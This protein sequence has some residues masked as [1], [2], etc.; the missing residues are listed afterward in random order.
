[1]SIEIRSK[2]YTS[3]EVRSVHDAKK[4]R[5]VPEAAINGHEARK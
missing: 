5:N 2:V 3:K 4:V 1:L